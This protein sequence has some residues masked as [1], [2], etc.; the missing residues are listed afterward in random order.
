MK[1]KYPPMQYLVH[2]FFYMPYIIYLSVTGK[3]E[4]ISSIFDPRF[5]N[6]FEFL[7]HLMFIER[8]ISMLMGVGIV[9]LVYRIS[10][11]VYNIEIG[12]VF[13]AV[14]I[15]LNPAFI[16]HAHIETVDIAVAFWFSIS[17]FF[18][19]RLLK[20]YEIRN[21]VLFGITS[22]VASS[23]KEQIIP[24]YILIFPYVLIR[25]AKYH[26]LS[27][28]SLFKN[29]RILYGGLTFL[30]TYLL[31]N[32]IL[33]GSDSY[34]WR[35]KSWLGP[36]TKPFAAHSNSIEG[37]VA[38]FF[39]FIKKL[40]DSMGEPL[41]IVTLIGIILAIKIE[42]NKSFPMFVVLTSYYFFL[43]PI[44]R[45]VTVRFTIPFIILL[46]IIS[47]R[48]LYFFYSDERVKMSLKYI[49]IFLI[50]GY[51]FIQAVILDLSLIYDSR[52]HAEKWL[53][54]NVSTD[55]K[56]EIYTMWMGYIPRL[57]VF[58]FSPTSVGYNEYSRRRITEN[59]NYTAEKL[60]ERNPDFIILTSTWYNR[61]KGGRDKLYFDSLK[62]GSIGYTI[63]E[64]F[65]TSTSYPSF[66]KIRRYDPGNR[67]SPTIIILARDSEKDYLKP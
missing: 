60:H 42:K 30:G 67:I 49:A 6:N 47:G 21:Y 40:A 52:Y 38:L 10:K 44:I 45:Y 62:N 33:T 59:P 2:V 8:S 54:D 27:L 56:I 51:S 29:K 58:G 39:D 18:Y 36:R 19:I 1:T 22:A 13:S 3:I 48:G 55:S 57:E 53:I 43:F 17:L 61:F 26:G 25:T 63:A 41:L 12:A 37:Q 5:L 28:R 35:M 65:N 34:I 64:I 4:S 32:I 11:E 31:L 23:T 66:N 7:T 50:L 15:A 14:I 9:Y 46:A 16:L 20:N 24:A